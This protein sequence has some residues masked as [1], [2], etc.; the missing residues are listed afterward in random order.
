MR[1][2]ALLIAGA[3]WLAQAGAGGD[4]VDPAKVTALFRMFLRDSAE[5]PMDVAVTTLVTDAAGREK[6]H[7]QGTVRLLFRGYSQQAERFT[8]KSQAGLMYRRLLHDSMAGDLAVFKAF[9]LV[10]PGKNGAPRV[11]VAEEDGG[12]VARNIETECP[13]FEM[14]TGELFPRRDCSRVE[15]RLVRE[16]SGELAVDHFRIETVNLPAPAKLR[17]LGQ[18]E[19]WKYAAEADVQ[20]A[21][22]PGDPRP[23]LVP[24]RVVTTIETNKGNIVLTEEHVLAVKK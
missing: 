24:K 13:D 21:Y 6:R 19:V 5:L 9:M 16:A 7:T 17:Y 14:R 22:L 8:M 3:V 23:F 4:P 11:K 1:T 2:I 18:V 15:F 20:K 12:L 10:A